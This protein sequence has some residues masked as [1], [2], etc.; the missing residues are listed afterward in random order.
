MEILRL[1]DCE[2]VTLYR[3]FANPIWRYR[4]VAL[5]FLRLLIMG[6]GKADSRPSGYITSQLSPLGLVTV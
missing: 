4:V 2:V 1:G 6:D 5:R 3:I